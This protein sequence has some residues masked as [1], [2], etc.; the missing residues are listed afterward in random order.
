MPSAAWTSGGPAGGPAVPQLT[1]AQGVALVMLGRLQE[2]AEVFDEAIEAAR[3]ANSPQGLAWTLF[4]RALTALTAGDL[5]LALR[6]GNE[7][8]VLLR[9]LDDRMISPFVRGVMAAALLE[10]GEPARC[11]DTLLP[12]GGGPEL[13][14]LPGIRQLF[15]LEVLTRAWL[16]LGRQHDAELSAAQAETAARAL[17]L[18]SATGLAQRA[19]AQVALAAGDPV[20]AAEAAL[21]STAAA[22]AIGAQVNAARV[23]I[24]AGK[25][26]AAAGDRVRGVT[27]LQ[28]AAAILDA[29]GVVGY[30]DEAKR[31]LRRL[32]RRYQRRSRATGEGLASLTRREREIAELV[33]AGKTNR[34]IAAELF[35]SHKTVETHPRHTF[36]KLGVSSRASVARTLAAEADDKT[37][38]EP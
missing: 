7:A 9:G 35:L 16:A 28:R 26:L 15:F 25:A 8:E 5:D 1:Q 36:G 21:T 4:N 17:G 37:E 2:A 29:C 19:R 13:P 20:Q 32:G 38:A 27:E 23:R 18:R 22:D 34:E 14:R 33:G 30:R 10:A 6:L 24:L 31:V 11:L 3:L 12:A